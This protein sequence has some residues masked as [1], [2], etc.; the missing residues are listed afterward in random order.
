MT[1]QREVS[2]KALCYIM[3]ENLEVGGYGLHSLLS[4]TEGGRGDLKLEV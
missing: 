4:P 2:E 3:C 1:R